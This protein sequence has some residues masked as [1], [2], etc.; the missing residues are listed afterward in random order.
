MTAIRI[1]LNQEFLR[2][3]GNTP[4]VADNQHVRSQFMRRKIK[5]VDPA[6]PQRQLSGRIH[7]VFHTG[8]SQGILL[9]LFPDQHYSVLIR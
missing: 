1:T 6:I 9:R 4:G 2:D 8:A 5:V 3:N 7:S